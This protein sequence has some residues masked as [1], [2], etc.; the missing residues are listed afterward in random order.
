[1]VK[2]INDVKIE[3]VN[4]WKGPVG[5]TATIKVLYYNQSG[6]LALVVPDKPIKIHELPQGE[7]NI[8]THNWKVYEVIELYKHQNGDIDFSRSHLREIELRNNLTLTINLDKNSN[9][10]IVGG[11][12]NCK[13]PLIGTDINSTWTNLKEK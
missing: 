9:L 8:S 6:D 10:S 5:A 1:M 12:L 4:P 2:E 11:Y 3:M 7:T 13:H